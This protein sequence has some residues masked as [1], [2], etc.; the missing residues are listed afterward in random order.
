MLSIYLHVVYLV[1]NRSP[2]SGKVYY[3]QQ[4]Q[5]TNTFQLNY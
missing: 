4:K 3:S 1:K 2:Y 5:N